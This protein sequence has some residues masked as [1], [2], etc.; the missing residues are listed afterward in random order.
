MNNLVNNRFIVLPETF[1]STI[2][3]GARASS[4]APIGD[5]E[6]ESGTTSSRPHLSYD[7][8]CSLSLLQPSSVLPRPLSIQ[9]KRL[10]WDFAGVRSGSKWQ[11][12]EVAE[13]NLHCL[14]CEYCEKIAVGP[15]RKSCERCGV[16]F[17]SRRCKACFECICNSDEE[18][19]ADMLDY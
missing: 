10:I 16:G 8:G 5:V 11:L 17:D 15:D 19:D 4:A 18:Y 1:I 3:F 9:I 12:I 14:V 2:L 7:H 6:D 13:A